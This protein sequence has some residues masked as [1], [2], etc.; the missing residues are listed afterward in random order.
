MEGEKVGV[1]YGHFSNTLK[2]IVKENNQKWQ[3]ERKRG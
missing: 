3:R 1:R 2:E